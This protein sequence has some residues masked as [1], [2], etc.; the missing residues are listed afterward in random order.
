[1][2]DAQE[3]INWQ[4]T[5]C[6]RGGLLYKAAPLRSERDPSCYAVAC[7]LSWSGRERDVVLRR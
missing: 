4:T 3:A 7:E 5:Q 1:M 6:K 2:H